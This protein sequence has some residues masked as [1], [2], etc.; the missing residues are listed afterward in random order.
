MDW[1]EDHDVIL[2]REVIVCDIFQHK[3]GSRERGST[4]EKIASSLNQLEMPWF[5]VDQR[6]LR[7]RLKKLLAQFVS[8]KNEE[9]KASGIHV[10]IRE[11][12]ELLQEIYDRR[13][14]WEVTF[15]EQSEEKSKK[16]DA[17]KKSAENIRFRAME[18]LTEIKKRESSSG[19]EET[20]RKQPRSSGS[21]TISYLREKSE[22]DFTLREQELVLREKELV[23]HNRRQELNEAQLS[24]MA[25]QSQQQTD[26][27]MLLIRKIAEK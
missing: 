23:L 13:H 2:C 25:K 22:K 17:E 9:E 14:E 7:D 16:N 20:P 19:E 8:K 18:R 1:T 3:P 26:A 27:L 15:N 6:S 10:E 4:L 12:D 21:D 5:K 11:I 24:Q